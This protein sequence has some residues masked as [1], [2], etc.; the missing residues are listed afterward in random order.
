MPAKLS[1][2]LSSLEAMLCSQGA[3]TMRVSCGH[4]KSMAAPS[5]A[6]MQQGIQRYMGFCQLV[7]NVPPSELSLHL[8]LVVDT[9]WLYLAFLKARQD[10]NLD[11]ATR[12]VQLAGTVCKWLAHTHPGQP[13]SSW[14]LE[15]LVPHM[16]TMQK[17]M[18]KEWAHIQS[19]LKPHH[20]PPSS[21]GARKGQLEGMP[22]AQELM[23]WKQLI[24]QEALE[25]AEDELASRLAVSEGGGGGLG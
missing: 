16:A 18:W 17:A 4:E 9:L 11:E 21:V 3:N 20:A 5:Y 24:K 7:C 22:S 6:R 15:Q 1:S 25:M 23:A 2:Q 12:Q 10:G 13:W 14:V 8:Y 19:V